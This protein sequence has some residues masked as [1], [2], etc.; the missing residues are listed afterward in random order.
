MTSGPSPSGP[1][2][3]A[4]TPTA[5]TSRQRQAALSPATRRAE[6]TRADVIE[7]VDEAHSIFHCIPGSKQFQKLFP[8]VQAV[9]GRT[10]V[11]KNEPKI[12]GI[13]EEELDK[14]IKNVIQEE[15]PEFLTMVGHELIQEEILAAAARES[16][17]QTTRVKVAMDSGAV[18]N[19]ILKKQLPTDATIEP[20]EDDT[21]FVGAGGD[22]IKRHGTCKTKMVDRWGR[23]ILCPWQV[24]DVSRP[25]HSVSEVAGP[26]DGDGDHD[27]LFNNKKC[28][29]VPP[30]IVERILKYVQ[31][32]TQYDRQGG[33]YVADM[34]LSDFVR[35]GQGR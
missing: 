28:V 20:N 9:E 26:E 32:I 8:D 13:S 33:L 7:D 3:T 22:R 31:P 18:R 25:L 21:H 14:I 34:T 11:A 4:S 24:A 10:P 1:R 2:A 16:A 35:Q 5:S 30:G 27:V 19:V 6:T 23:T 29:V 17:A 15:C 12:Q